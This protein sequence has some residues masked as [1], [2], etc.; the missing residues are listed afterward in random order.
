MSRNLT[1]QDIQAIKALISEERLGTFR[2][3]THSDD[4]AI[5]LH[6]AAMMLSASLMS[7][8]GMIEIA[9]RNAVCDQISTDYGVADFLRRPPLGL[10]WHALEKKKIEDAES[11]ARR[12]AY[13][14]LDNAGKEALDGRAFPNGVPPNIKHTTLARKRQATLVVSSGQ[15]VS[16]LTIFFWKRLFSEQYEPTLWKRSL[17]KVFPNK[18]YERS[19]IAEHLEVLYQIRNRLA[20]HE[21]VY[22]RRLEQ[23]RGAIEFV[24]HNMK[25]RRPDPESNFAKFVLPHREQL[26]SQ[27]AVFTATFNRLTTP[28]NERHDG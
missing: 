25:S 19:D 20:H 21:L 7:V 17:K 5:E 13:S 12:A 2:S 9:L 11:Q 16:Q 26:D 15:V 10:H 23:I 4:D 1:D 8:T 28:P 14:K 27:V 24:A 22:G 3:I 18:R 6:Q